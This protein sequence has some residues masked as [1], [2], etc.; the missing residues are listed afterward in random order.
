MI[1]DEEMLKL[2]QRS[3]EGSHPDQP[4]LCFWEVEG[5]QLVFA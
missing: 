5:D 3:L 2:L 1:S 4:E